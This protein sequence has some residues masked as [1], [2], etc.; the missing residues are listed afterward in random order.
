M[1]FGL[2]TAAWA[3][4]TLRS[5]NIT[6]ETA[7]VIEVLVPAIFVLAALLFICFSKG[8]PLFTVR[9]HERRDNR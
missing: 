3:L 6:D 4:L 8:E 9:A 2:A 1:T 7:M 5:L